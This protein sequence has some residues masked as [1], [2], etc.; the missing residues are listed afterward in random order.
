MSSK[1]LRKNLVLVFSAILVAATLLCGC[2]N[3]EEPE[4]ENPDLSSN[5]GYICDLATLEVYYHNVARYNQ[6]SDFPLKLGNIGYKRMWFEYSGI[7]EI[8]VT[9]SKVTISE[10]DEN[11][12]VTIYVPQAEIL[13]VNLD[14]N[15][16]TDPVVETGWFTT[17]STEEKTEALSNA[18]T[19]MEKE[20]DKDD[21]LKYQARKR[22]KDLLES[23]VQNTGDL[24]GKRY[25]VEWI[26]G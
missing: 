1:R 23:Y 6:E 14:E 9:A 17:L 12:V 15:S 18:Q 16:I 25:T 13:N 20:A 24:I 2:Q 26:E 4:A 19:G 10:P 5:A 22:A 21:T 3:T 7:V 11:G 8:G